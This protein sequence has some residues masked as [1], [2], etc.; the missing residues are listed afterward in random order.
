MVRALCA[1]AQNGPLAPPRGAQVAC[2]EVHLRR[3]D[4][5]AAQPPRQHF[6]GDTELLGERHFAAAILQRAREGLH[7][8]RGIGHERIL[9]DAR[10]CAGA[11][12]YIKVRWRTDVRRGGP[13]APPTRRDTML[14]RSGIAAAVFAAISAGCTPAQAPKAAAINDKVYAVTPAEI[15]VKGAIIR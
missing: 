9:P 12:A 6:D 15:T 13:Q 4:F 10:A 1:T 5:M 2:P 14:I 7:L 11:L 8:R 3:Y